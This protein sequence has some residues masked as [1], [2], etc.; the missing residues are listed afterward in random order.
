LPSRR[1]NKFVFRINK[2]QGQLHKQCQ[3]EKYYEITVRRGWSVSA[4]Y[5]SPNRSLLKFLQEQSKCCVNY[6]CCDLFSSHWQIRFFKYSFYP[7]KNW[8]D[9]YVMY[10][11]KT[12]ILKILATVYLKQYMVIRSGA[13]FLPHS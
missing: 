7:A 5:T 6:I 10:H 8:P 4:P 3:G 12:H 11:G 1:Y 2:F 9:H 13:F